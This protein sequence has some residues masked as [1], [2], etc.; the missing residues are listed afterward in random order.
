MPMNWTILIGICDEK[1]HMCNLSYY[2]IAFT[3]FL[4]VCNLTS[5][6]SLVAV[7]LHNV[8]GE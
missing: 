8:R 1:G 3:V 2:H 6:V 4:V 7:V 5:I